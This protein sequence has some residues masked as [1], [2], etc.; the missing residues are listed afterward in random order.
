MNSFGRVI[1]KLTGYLKNITTKDIIIIDTTYK[2][3]NNKIKYQQDSDTYEIIINKD[4]IYILRN[5]NEVQSTMYFKQNKYTTC[6]YKIKE[7]DINLQI[8]IYTSKLI[9][10]E[11]LILIKYQVENTDKYEYKIEIEV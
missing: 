10:E 5:T 2:K 3:I 7:N 1:I 4:E 8:E 11:N 9:I 6:D